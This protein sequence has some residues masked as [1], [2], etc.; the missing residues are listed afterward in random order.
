VPSTREFG[1]HGLAR[2]HGLSV[3]HQNA[4]VL[5][6]KQLEPAA[7]T[8]YAKTIAAA[9]ALSFP[10]IALNPAGYQTCDLHHANFGVPGIPALSPEPDRHALVFN[11]RLVERGIEEFTG[12]VGK[13][14]NRPIAWH[15]VHMNV[16][17][18]HKDAD[19]PMRV[20]PEAEFSPWC[21]KK[22]RQ[23]SA[24]RGCN[25]QLI[26]RR[27]APFGIAKEG[28]NPKHHRQA[29]PAGPSRKGKENRIRDD[30]DDDERPARPMNDELFQIVTCVPIST[31]R[32][33]GNL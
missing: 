29:N 16:K 24:V 21:R 6:Q 32:L 10:E 5:R 11:A 25:D 19:F 31:T 26:P 17:N 23:N 7:E 12:T 9:Y 22:N 2:F 14:L 1:D 33:G 18:R 28:D 4:S 30:G 3:A 15:P 8:D 20:L 13:S 27:R